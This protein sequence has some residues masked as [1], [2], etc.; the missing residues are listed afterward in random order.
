M[1]L[2]YSIRKKSYSISKGKQVRVYFS[3]SKRHH[4]NKFRCITNKVRLQVSR[5]INKNSQLKSHLISIKN[6]MKEISNSTLTKLIEDSEISKCQSILLHEIFA[7]AKFKNPKS[8]HYS[9]NWMI[10]C[11]LFQIRFIYIYVFLL[12]CLYYIYVCV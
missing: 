2:L 12:Y 5:T 10:L 1:R 7:A 11:L 4:L 8:R 3:P 6:Q 9:D